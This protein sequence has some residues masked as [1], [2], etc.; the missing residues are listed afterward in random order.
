MKASGYLRTGFALVTAAA[1]IALAQQAAPAGGNEDGHYSREG[2]S[3]DFSARPAPGAGTALREGQLAE[4]EFRIREEATGNPVRSNVPSAWMDMAQNIRG[5]PGGEQQT[6]REK[7]ALYLKGVV[8]MRPM[9]DLNSYYVILMNEEPSL[10]VIDPLVSMAG[11]T[12]TRATIALKSRGVDWVSHPLTKSLYVTEPKSG[13]VEVVDTE[14]FRV[15]ATI[16]AWI[17]PA[18]AALQPDGRFVWVGNNDP[19]GGGVTVIDTATQRSV[20]YVA[21]GRGHHEIAFTPDSARAFVTNRD[22]GTVTMIDAASRKKL[23]ETRTGALPISVAVSA[24][25]G[26]A[27]VAD[28]REGKVTVLDGRTGDPLHAIRL[29]P[30]LGPL[31]FTED[32]RYAFVVNVDDAKVYVIDASNDALVHEID[33]EPKPFQLVFTRNFAYVRSLA[34]ERVTMVNLATVGAGKNPIV[35]K[36]NAGSTPPG[37]VDDL[38]IA[39][40]LVAGTSEAAMLVVN[41]AENATYFYMEGMNSAA[42]DYQARGSHARAVMVVD[43]GLKEMEPGL[44]RGIVRLPAPGRYDVGLLLDSPRVVHCFSAVVEADPALVAK[45]GETRIEYLAG[46]GVGKPGEKRLVR[47]RLT[48]AVTGAPRK[49]LPDVRVVSFLAPNRERREVIARET[50]AGVYEAEVSLTEQGAYYVQA[51]SASARFG[52]NDLPH[53][54]IRVNRSAS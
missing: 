8:G 28:G 1:G 54:T 20:G 33:V 3:I 39:D 2:L 12:S 40:T 22:G 27:Y 21:T 45:R 7:V 43:R 46:E 13:Q 15:T 49:G 34:S 30:G 41:P 25:S 50:D 32:G 11:T 35:Q 26:N 51:A 47:F 16:P 4:I 36:F 14:T 9:V 29:K 42:S 31:R 38:V 44:Y 19:K 52:L 37:R 48:D 23:H 10:T 17:A 24:R 5:R 53:L 6:C 18:R